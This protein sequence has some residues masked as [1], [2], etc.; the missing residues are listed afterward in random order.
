MKHARTLHASTLLIAVMMIL[1]SFSFLTQSASQPVK[2]NMVLS[3]QSIRD[4][5]PL[6]V[7]YEF[8]QPALKKVVREGVQYD[9]ITM[10]DTQLFGNPGLPEMLLRQAMIL[11]PY[12]TT[13]NTIHVLPGE[14]ILI[15]SG[16]TLAPNLNE[17][18]ASYNGP[19]QLT[20]LDPTVYASSEPYPR[21]LFSFDGIQHYRGLTYAIVALYPV[22]YLPLTGTLS[23]YHDMTIQITLTKTSG[24][25]PLF[26]GY[27][28]DI[29]S[30]EK[31]ADDPDAADTYRDALTSNNQIR[32][33]DVLL[34]TTSELR[35]GF[36]RLVRNHASRNIHTIIKILGVD[37]P[38]GQTVNQT[39]ENIRDYIRTAYTTLGI[40]YVLLG[41]DIDLIPAAYL[42]FGRAWDFIWCN[43]TGPSDF[44]Y[45]C[46]DGPYNYDGDDRWGEPW[47]GANG[48][49]VDLLPEVY[50][51][52]ACVQNLTEVN[53]FINKTLKAQLT[54]TPPVYTSRA[55]MAG[56][57]I[58]DNPLIWGGN[59]TDQ[60]IDTS[61]GDNMVT[62]GIPSDE[63]T[64]TKLYDR[65]WQLHG[66]PRPSLIN[67]GGWPTALLEQYIQ[68]G[69]YFINNLGHS[70]TISDMK[71]HID[72]V[73]RLT[74]KNLSFIYSQGCFAGSYDMGYDGYLGN[75]SDC[76]AEYFTIKSEYGAFAGIWNTRYGWVG[77]S[78]QF[79]RQ[80]W[81]AV[82]D[83]GI[84]IISRAHQDSKIDLVS[85][86]H[87]EEFM[88]FCCYEATYFGD[89]TLSFQL[90]FH[91]SAHGP[92]EGVI[93]SPVQFNGT[94][95]GGVPPY[96]MEWNF[97]DGTTSKKQ[98]PLKTYNRTGTYPVNFTVT[99]R[100]GDMKSSETSVVIVDKLQIDINGPYLGI[101]DIPVQFQ[102]SVSGGFTPYT[103]DWDFG[104]ESEHSPYLNP[105]HAYTTPGVYTVTF[106]V[107]DRNEHHLSTNTTVTI[108]V[109]PQV[110]W[111]D[112]DFNESTPGWGYTHYETIQRGVAAVEIG[113]I[114]NVLPGEYI[115]GVSIVKPLHLVGAD[116]SQ[117]FIDAQYN[118][119]CLSVYTSD[120]FISGFTLQHSN[121]H[122]IYLV[123]AD[124]CHISHNILEGVEIESTTSV[125]IED[126][127]FLTNGITIVGDDITYWNT[128]TI[129]RNRLGDQYIYYYSD[130]H[131]PC[132]VPTDAGQVIIANSSQITTKN[133]TF[134]L[135]AYAVEVGFSS[136]IKI[137]GNTFMGTADYVP[138][139]AIYLHMSSDNTIQENFITGYQSGMLINSWSNN[140][141]IT[142]NK[143]INT[144]N[145]GAA[146]YLS[147]NQTMS[148]NIITGSR[149]GIQFYFS[150]ENHILNNSIQDNYEDGVYLWLAG[151]NE[152]IDNHI[153]NN[154]RSNIHGYSSSYLRFE[155]NKLTGSCDGMYL[156][157][158]SDHSTFIENDIQSFFLEMSEDAT[159]RN[160][161][162]HSYGLVLKGTQQSHYTNHQI[163]GS[164]INGK[165]IYYY[166]NSQ[167]PMTVPDDAGQVILANCSN[168]TIQHL[169]IDHAW[170][171][172][173]LAYASRNLITDNTLAQNEHG[174]WM[175]QSSDN[176]ISSNTIIENTIGAR[177][178]QSPANTF[179]DNTFQDNTQY[180]LWFQPGSSAN[181][182]YNNNF[183]D[184][185]MAQAWTEE[186]NY[187]HQPYP[188]GGNYWSDY[189]SQY[190]DPQDLNQDG[191]WD[192]PYYI[193]GYDGKSIPNYDYQPYVNVNGW[194]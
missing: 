172:I 94:V 28:N 93:G 62:H 55:L 86:I 61:Y 58:D 7:S 66:W 23:Y 106:N 52:R 189:T 35:P 141:I 151:N 90:Q 47:D 22:E 13:V 159:I 111:V 175:I 154:C 2:N 89:P 139:A 1:S 123:L 157:A 46:L 145:E 147:F 152:F 56:A 72:N 190:P 182:V 179:V 40:D 65:D 97:G 92:Y 33:Q 117:T 103:F 129:E 187:W 135:A 177:L 191:I 85:R 104:D 9:T 98:N 42:Y 8:Q 178:E 116:A 18:P 173:H 122:A 149:V 183:I 43:V 3:E 51:G 34:I 32:Q 176:T 74:N 95:I 161:T 11:L 48:S 125:T 144:W 174:I 194:H 150:S 20:V 4:D 19:R 131:E 69:T 44:Y 79:A 57:L 24:E 171:G 121:P 71:L 27:E 99:D 167:E 137:I 70:S 37:I 124:R 156:R 107:T 143:I 130:V 120:V 134:S 36:Q 146:L 10:P 128:H 25:T 83:E 119:P 67:N 64:I 60:L 133:L 108:Y 136:D 170:I 127:V 110:V 63:Y 163:T 15:G 164:R 41:G 39:C 112:D 59:Y 126:N 16:Y 53:H 109:P 87:S 88:R 140:N 30:A 82:F 14:K 49:D 162:F 77:P 73:T 12:G 76:I 91:I 118:G 113:G 38:V 142:G 185:W 160:N 168:V 26:R 166:A 50:I 75:W 169:I 188:I 54:N 138:Q 68:N 115:N 17:Y 100:L 192:Q 132:Q 186:I 78:N 148:N 102:G 101:I 96:R 6:T 105:T 153:I 80:F 180:G 158:N 45:S 5:S 29:A 31:K 181:M 81:D 165:P 155:H 84:T 184:N 193:Y 114:V 21:T